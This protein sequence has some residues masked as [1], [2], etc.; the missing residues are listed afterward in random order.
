MKKRKIIIHIGLPKTASSYLQDVFFPRLNNVVY[1]GRPYT[2]ENYAFNSL[3]YA[4]N[5]LYNDLV[6]R[7]EINHIRN[8]TPKGDTILISDEQFSGYAFYN[9]INRGIIAE[10]LSKVIPDAEIVLF[11]RGQIDL[12]MSLYNQVVKNGWFDNN[13]DESFLYQPGNGFSLEKWLEGE[14][15]WNIENRF[16]NH[17]SKFNPEHVRYSKLYLYYSELF[18]KVHVFLYEDFR[19]D[20]KKCLQ[21]LS[22]LL[23]T[24]FPFSNWFKE[25]PHK[26]IVNK[27][28]ENKQLHE[29]LIQNKLS[30]IFPIYKSRLHLRC[31]RI[32]ARCISRIVSDNKDSNKE[33]VISLLKEQDIFRDNYLL[34]EKFKL[35]MEKYP[36]QYFGATD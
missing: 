2:Q 13:L 11:L 1:I 32:F 18:S 34:N 9:F 17:Q 4:D 24:E 20:Q 36:K 33:H 6:I 27:R 29:K 15:G 22:S 10:R 25:E 26:N 16:I 31:T 14:R 35:G 28:L 19:R 12:I 21:Q 3:Q 5:S 23:S 7:E 8:A 30:H